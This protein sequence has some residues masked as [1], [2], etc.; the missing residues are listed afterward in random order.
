MQWYVIPLLAVVAYIYLN[1][2]GKGNWSAV[3]LGIATWAAELIWEMFNGL[4]LHF[5]QHAPLWSTPGSSAFVIYAGLNVEIT[6]FFSVSA[7]L[8]IKALPRDKSVRI[9]GIP[10]R[11]LIPSGGAALAVAA[12]VVLNRCGML[13]WDWR[14]WGWPHFYLILIAYCAPALGLVWIH[15]NVPLRSKRRAA[16]ILLALAAV[17]HIVFASLLKWV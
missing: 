13:I 4:V 6:L 1:E 14:F 15:D 9:M 11:L 2:S 5:T 7:L 8:L 3:W 10:N 16:G 12:E 17:C